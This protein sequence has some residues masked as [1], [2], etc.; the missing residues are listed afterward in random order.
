MTNPAVVACL[1][2]ASAGAAAAQGR[3]P[4]PPAR[5]AQQASTIIC[6]TRVF[7]GDI[8]TDPKMAKAVPEGTFTLR[9]IPPPLCRDT[10]AGSA[11]TVKQRLPFVLGPKR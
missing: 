9:S 1:V 3:S 10:F 8:A 11:A 6:G 2:V 4:Q 7:R 5:S